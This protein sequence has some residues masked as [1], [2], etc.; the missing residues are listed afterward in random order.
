MEYISVAIDGPAGAGKSSV[1]KAV[2]KD[3]GFVYVDTGAMYRTVALAAV[4]AGIDPCDNKTEVEKI[5]DK[6]N[7]TLDYKDGEICVYLNGEDVSK[8][9][10]MPQISRGASA[11]AT[12]P[13]VRQRLVEM[14][15]N[16]AKKANIIM[17]GRDICGVVLPNAQV[18]IFLTASVDTRAQRRFDEL[19]EKGAECEYEDIKK[20][21]TA[22][23]K[24]DSEREISP[25]KQAEDAVLLDTSDMSFDEVADAIKKM[26]TEAGYVL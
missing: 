3:M 19:K 9:I 17:D 22:R 24:N 8:E 25:L 1:A 16:M 21:I 12:M 2:A 20:D 14:Q 7:I 6:T 11:V 4:R 5:V 18:K 10:R 13:K 15:R 26:I 23:D